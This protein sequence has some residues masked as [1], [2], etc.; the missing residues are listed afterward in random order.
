MTNKMKPMNKNKQAKHF[1][2]SS[3][4]CKISK[5]KNKRNDYDFSGEKNNIKKEKTSKSLKETHTKKVNDRNFKELYPYLLKYLGNKKINLIKLKQSDIVNILRLSIAESYELSVYR[6]R[7]ENFVNDEVIMELN[8]EYLSNRRQS[9]KTLLFCLNKEGLLPLEVID[10]IKD[11]GL[12]L[13]VPRTNIFKIIPDKLVKDIYRL[14]C[15]DKEK[16]NLNDT[17]MPLYEEKKNLINEYKKYCNEKPEYYKFVKN[18]LYGYASD[19]KYYYGFRNY[20]MYN[21]I[22][23]MLDN[24]YNV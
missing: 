7:I 24:M 6:R 1:K 5:K 8:K 12:K 9:L 15:L 14:Y 18:V 3:N 13:I 21:Y 16:N 20:N 23:E 2:H 11:Y 22:S 17:I 4:N 10:I 19:R